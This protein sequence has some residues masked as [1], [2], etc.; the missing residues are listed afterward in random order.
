MS[1]L[2]DLYNRDR[3][4]LCRKVD[5]N[6]YLFQP[7]EFMMYVLAILEN[8]EGKFLVTRRS[9]NK[10]WAAGGWEMPGGGAKSGETSEEAIQ[11][12]V[13]EETN[14]DVQNGQVVYSYFNEDETRHDNYFVDIYRFKFDFKLSDVTLNAKE[15]IDCK[16]VSLEE[17]V[18]MHKEQP[19]LH[20][21]RIMKALQQKK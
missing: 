13:K 20:F 15:S 5:R 14:L 7:N 12:E 4:S 19:F 9:L 1:E 10:K 6:A 16:F 11:R 21:E 2:I 8:E 18:T 3:E 17:L